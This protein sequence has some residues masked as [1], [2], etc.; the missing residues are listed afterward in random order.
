MD[1]GR[2]SAYSRF[3]K[4]IKSFRIARGSLETIDF[5]PF[6]TFNFNIEE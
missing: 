4:W 3:A 6:K 1:L 2:F 5:L